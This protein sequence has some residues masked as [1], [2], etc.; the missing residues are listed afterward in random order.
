M[1]IYTIYKITNLHNKKTYVGWTS[2]DPQQ[3]FTEHITSNKSIVSQAI[4]KHGVDCFTFEVICQ[5]LDHQYSRILE[6]LMIQENNS[7]TTHQGGW[8]YNVNLGGITGDQHSQHTRDKMSSTRRGKSLSHDHRQKLTE[9]ARS[10]QYTPHQIEQIKQKVSQ[11]HTGVYDIEYDNGTVV[12]VNGLDDI[13][14][15]LGISVNY[16]R[17]TVSSQKFVKGCRIIKCHGKLR[18]RKFV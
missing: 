17:R 5:S 8:G 10:R 1:I 11:L 16:F 7:L 2:R 13:C 6:Q 14:C 18:L 4:K 3:R 9:A 15:D 12:T